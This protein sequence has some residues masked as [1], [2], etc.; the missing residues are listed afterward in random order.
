[1]AFVSAQPHQS[2]QIS[3]ILHFAIYYRLGLGYSPL[4][5]IANNDL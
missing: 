3:N 2:F 5:L 4:A 1:M